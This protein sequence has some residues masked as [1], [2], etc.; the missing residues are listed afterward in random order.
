MNKLKVLQTISSMS[1]SAGG[2]TTCT[3]NLLKGLKEEGIEI[4]LLTFDILSK[5]DKLISNSTEF[6]RL[7]AP[8]KHPRFGFS[9]E[10]TKWLEHHTNYDLYHANALWQYPTH[11]TLKAA[12]TNNKPCIISTHGMLY[13]EGLKKSKWIKKLSLFLYQAND[14]QNATAFHATSE[15]EKNYIRDFGLKQPIAVIP[16]AIDTSNF[17][18]PNF[19]PKTDK[20]K[21]GFMG[22][23]N[24][25][26]NIEGLIKAWALADS[27]TSQHE[28]IIMGDGDLKYKETLIKLA[29]D[30]GVTNIKYTGFVTGKI[31]DDLLSQLSYLVLPSKSENFG[32]V[33]P[34]A[35]WK[36]IPVIASKG[37][38]WQELEIHKCGWW[39]DNDASSL[40]NVLKIALQIDE[41]ERIAMGKRGNKL[42]AEK[43]TLNAVGKM[44]K[45]FYEWI[46]V[47]G[48]K[49]EYVNLID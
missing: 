43:Y 10:W 20:R 1:L 33:V 12:K 23:L 47:G 14:L 18:L 26:K 17:G 31:Q 19:E 30:L 37:T 24:P 29:K 44:M 28:L 49:P 42:I 40:S 9:K 22:R 11:A 2:P 38:P 39:S 36:G 41:T 7:I 5:D 25:I 34:E 3:F 45:A 35:L 15:Q 32:M 8:S 4:Q 27:V 13:P 16:N 46:I 21:V 6:M 48:V